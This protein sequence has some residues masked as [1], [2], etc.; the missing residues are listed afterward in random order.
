MNYFIFSLYS[1]NSVEIQLKG[2]APL[3]SQKFNLSGGSPA[4]TGG[5][6]PPASPT[7]IR[8]RNTIFYLP[9]AIMKVIRMQMKSRSRG[10]RLDN[11]TPD[12]VAT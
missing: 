11:V 7:V 3:D 1:Q 12:T 6:A 4:P 5:S 10:K 8:P 2:R 9:G